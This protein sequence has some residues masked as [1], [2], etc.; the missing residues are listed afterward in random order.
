MILLID[1]LKKWLCEGLGIGYV[2]IDYLLEFGR[3]SV[4]RVRTYYGDSETFE[5]ERGMCPQGG[6]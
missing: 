4:Q 3:R 2:T 1:I 5:C 6:D